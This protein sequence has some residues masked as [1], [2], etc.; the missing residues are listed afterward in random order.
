MLKNV[1]KYRRTDKSLRRIID[2]TLYLA[3]QGL[4]FR[5]RHR[6]HFGL[7]E[8]DSCNNGKFLELLKL[9]AKYDS[10]LQTHLTSEHRNE[11]Y[12]SH[13]IQ[14]DIIKSLADEISFRNAKFRKQARKDKNMFLNDK[15][16]Q[17]EKISSELLKRSMENS[18]LEQE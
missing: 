2:V 6:E 7:G 8:R 15:C 1:F 16:A 5:G 4:A 3:K 12:F 14:N 17:A 13:S 10:L 11:M 9:L 18:Q